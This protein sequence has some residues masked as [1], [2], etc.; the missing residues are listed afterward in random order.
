MIYHGISKYRYIMCQ[1][2][3][4]RGCACNIDMEIFNVEIIKLW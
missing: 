4:I 2:V 3:G 1:G